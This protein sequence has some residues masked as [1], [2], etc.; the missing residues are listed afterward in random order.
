M[1]KIGDKN[2]HDLTSWN[3]KELRKL[4]IQTK[5]RL[6]SLCLAPNKEVSKKHLLYGFDAKMCE[7]LILN[8]KRA[9]KTLSSK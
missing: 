8:I 3:M 5:N 7:D 9:E 6:E 4:R 2:I 1:A